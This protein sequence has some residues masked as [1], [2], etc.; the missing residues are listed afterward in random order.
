M[1]QDRV[2]SFQRPLESSEDALVSVLRRGTQEL[3]AKAIEKEDKYF[4]SLYTSLRTPE[5]S[6]QVVRNGYLPTRKIQTGVG[7]VDVQIPRHPKGFLDNMTKIVQ[8]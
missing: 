6:P 5:G 7:S 2:I 3:L 4:Q 8:Q 1:S